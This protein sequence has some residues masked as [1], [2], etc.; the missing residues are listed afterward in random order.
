[1]RIAVKDTHDYEMRLREKLCRV[2]GL[3]HGIPTF[4]LGHLKG[5]SVPI[6]AFH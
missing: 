6:R 4:V 3:R 5:N 2:R 1:V